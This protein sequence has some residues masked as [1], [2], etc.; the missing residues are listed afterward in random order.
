ML[1]WQAWDD[2]DGDVS[3]RATAWGA[4]RVDTSLPTSDAAPYVIVYSV[5][6]SSGNPAQEVRRRVHVSNPCQ[7]AETPCFGAG[8]CTLGGVCAAEVQ[9]ATAEEEETTVAADS[10]PSVTL[11][12]GAV[13][14]VDQYQPFAAC[15]PWSPLSAVCDR[16]AVARDEE[17]GDLGGR[18]EACSTGREA[19][20]F[21]DV[22]VAGCGVDTHFPGKYT[23]RF[24]VVDSA[25][26]VR[27]LEGNLE[28]EARVYCRCK[29]SP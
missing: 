7:A 17:D 19:F 26:Q 24:R 1:R 9:R 21:R 3:A 13:L 10:P 16:G 6:D 25:G 27:A 18:V 20:F 14:Q 29:V 22:G 11:V 2:V 4:G 23:V 5:S 8:G 12:G 15:T 28:T